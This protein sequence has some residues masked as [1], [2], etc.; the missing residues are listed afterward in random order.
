MDIDVLAG[1]TETKAGSTVAVRLPGAGTTGRIWTVKAPPGVR[2][3]S[4]HR[5]VA[6]SFGGK[7]SE[8]AFLA[9]DAAGRHEVVF[10]LGTSGGEDPDRVLPFVIDAA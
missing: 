5:K 7:G 10:S 8:T 2:L 3:L 1:R 6:K 4:R 9:V